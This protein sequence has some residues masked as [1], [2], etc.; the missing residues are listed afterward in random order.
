MDDSE[1]DEQIK[2]QVQEWST[3]SC[4]CFTVELVRGDLSKS[5]TFQPEFTYPIFGDEEAIFGYQD[6]EIKLTFAAHDL[7]PHL[8]ISYSKKFPANGEVKPTD[9]HEALREFLPADAFSKWNAKDALIDG[10][11]AE[12]T[13]PGEMIKRYSRK[14]VE[15]ESCLARTVP[16]SLS[17]VYFEVWH[18]L[19]LR[20]CVKAILCQECCSSAEAQKPSSVSLIRSLSLAHLRGSANATSETMRRRLLVSETSHPLTLL[21]FCLQVRIL[22]VGRMWTMCRGPRRMKTSKFGAP[23]SQI[24][25][26]DDF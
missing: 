16:P 25:R 10:R 7:K 4:E 21:P 20:R 14:G 5:A 24:R 17:D 11:A 23:I 6:L 15:G 26:L 8:A 2:A 9:I 18:K 1:L 19:P 22:R 13:P 3:N 12:F